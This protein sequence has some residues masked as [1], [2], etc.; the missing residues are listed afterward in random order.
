MIPFF[1]D[2]PYLEPMVEVFREEELR[3]RSYPQLP[4]L[5]EREVLIIRGR[6]KY[7]FF[8]S[9]ELHRSKGKKKSL[10]RDKRGQLTIEKKYSGLVLQFN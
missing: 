4:Q 2:L 9:C 7:F 3:F 1:M 10:A 5:R 8:P 6:A